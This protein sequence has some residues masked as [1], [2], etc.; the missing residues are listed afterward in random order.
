MRRQR[1]GADQAHQQPGGAEQAIFQ[2]EGDRD[3]RSD[4]DELPHQ[5]PVDAPDVSEYLIFP[6]RPAAGGKPE[7]GQEHRG[8]DHGSGEP[9]A[10]QFQPRQPHSP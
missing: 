9:G 4:D 8:I 5:M 10:E 3:R 1:G 2:Q 7:T 6:E